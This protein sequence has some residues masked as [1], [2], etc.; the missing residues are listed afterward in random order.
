MLTTGSPSDGEVFEMRRHLLDYMG[1]QELVLK[2]LATSPAHGLSQRGLLDE[3]DN[4]SGERNR[5]T[6]R[7][8]ITSHTVLDDLR[9]GIGCRPDA[10]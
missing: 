5:L 4:R 9:H 2:S 1:P 10:R 8:K 6:W 7:D 3:R